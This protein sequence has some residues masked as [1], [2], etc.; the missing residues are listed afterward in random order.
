MCRLD[1]RIYGT[2]FH[3]FC[4]FQEWTHLDYYTNTHFIPFLCNK[5]VF[6]TWHFIMLSVITNVYHKKTEGPTWWN[7]SQPQEDWKCFFWQLEMFDVCTKGDTAHIDTI[8]TFLPHT[9]QHVDAFCF[10]YKIYLQHAP[11]HLVI[12]HAW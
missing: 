3:K 4:G 10:Y 5:P 12:L 9:R 6:S 11:L 7:C 1:S 2:L 8:F